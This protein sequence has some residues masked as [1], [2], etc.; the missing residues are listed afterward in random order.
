MK[1]EMK[2]II[3]IRSSVQIV[4][5]DHRLSRSG[6]VAGEVVLFVARRLHEVVELHHY[7][8]RHHISILQKQSQKKLICETLAIW[9]FENCI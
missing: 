5:C 1:K 7:D 6:K 2:A 9:Y 3:P 8:V 4:R